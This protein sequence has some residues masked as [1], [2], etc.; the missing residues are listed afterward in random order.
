[1]TPL[2][3]RFNTLIYTPSG[4]RNQK[5]EQL[6]KIPA[7]EVV[8]TTYST[9]QVFHTLSVMKVDVVLLCQEFSVNDLNILRKN[10]PDVAVV[11]YC[12][13]EEDLCEEIIDK[14]VDVLVLP[15]R[16]SN[17]HLTLSRITRFFE[18]GRLGVPAFSV[19]P[20]I[21]IKDGHETHL[22]PPKEIMYI[23]SVGEYVRFHTQNK[24]IIALGS[25]K[26]LQKELP[27]NYLQVHRSFIVNSG[28]M[29]SFSNSQI[30]LMG[31]MIIPVGRTFRDNLKS[32]IL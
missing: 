31:G 27:K 4:F 9:Q 15:L 29:T 2:P 16:P 1:M 10:H 30:V 12:N 7:F 23:E 17:L 25:L 18:H 28:F 32:L 6:L 21:K 19:E 24:K 5:T 26:K 20:P 3:L 8:N 11:V 13:E 22:I 14:V